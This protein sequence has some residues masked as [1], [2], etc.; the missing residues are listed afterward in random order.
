M[1][2]RVGK[3]TAPRDAIRSIRADNDSSAEGFLIGFNED[4]IC[5]GSNL[6][7]RHALSD[8]YSPVFCLS[9]QPIVELVA[10]DDAQGMSVGNA[11]VQAPGFKIKMDVIGIDMRH[12]ADVESEPLQ[13]DLRIDH[14][15][16]GAKLGARVMGFFQNQKAW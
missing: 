11:E 15:S 6:F 5:L 16:A 4:V 3:N 13:N 7:N 14:E 8:L 9:C 10:A 12:F 1:H 2:R